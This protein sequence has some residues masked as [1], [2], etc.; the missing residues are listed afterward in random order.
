[1]YGKNFQDE[2]IISFYNEHSIFSLQSCYLLFASS[3]AV[4]LTRI[5]MSSGDPVDGNRIRM[6]AVVVSTGTKYRNRRDSIVNK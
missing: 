3:M 1:M 6:I 4:W 2:K 5:A